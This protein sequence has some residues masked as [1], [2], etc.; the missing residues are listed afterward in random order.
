MD[1]PGK[2][3][4]CPSQSV[5]VCRIKCI[6]GRW[7]ISR[8][9]SPGWKERHHVSE[10]G[11]LVWLVERRPCGIFGRDLTTPPASKSLCCPPMC[12]ML[13]FANFDFC[14]N[15]NNSMILRKLE[16]ISLKQLEKKW[17]SLFF[18]F[19]TIPLMWAMLQILLLILLVSPYKILKVWF[20]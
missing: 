14:H 12:A 20:V 16:I 6:R 18:F 13:S 5:V 17:F 1:W 15:I 3:N 11:L 4:S 7:T 19:K 2:L 9:T 10:G 8:I